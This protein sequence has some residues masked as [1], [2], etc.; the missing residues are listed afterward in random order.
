MKVGMEGIA[1][2]N[3]QLQSRSSL[4][5]ATKKIK[6][7]GRMYFLPASHFD[8]GDDETFNNRSQDFNREE[9]SNSTRSPDALTFEDLSEDGEVLNS[10]S[11]EFNYMA[12][13]RYEEVSQLVNYE[14]KTGS[15]GH[16]RV[17]VSSSPPK[18]TYKLT[19]D[20]NSLTGEVDGIKFTCATPSG[21]SQTV[22]TSLRSLNAT[23][24]EDLSEGE[25]EIV[26]AYS[27]DDKD[28][29]TRLTEDTFAIYMVIDNSHKM[30][31]NMDGSEA[32]SPDSMRA[33]YMREGVTRLLNRLSD[34]ENIYVGIQGFFSFA[35]IKQKQPLSLLSDY[36]NLAMFRSLFDPSSF[37]T[38][39][40]NLLAMPDNMDPEEILAPSIGCNIGDG[41]R[42]GL[43]NVI[44]ETASMPELSNSKKYL[45]LTTAGSPDTQ[46][47]DLNI[48]GGA[49]ATRSFLQ[50]NVN[51]SAATSYFYYGSTP[52][53]AG[54]DISYGNVTAT[55][56]PGIGFYGSSGVINRNIGVFYAR[57]MAALVSAE[58]AFNGCFIVGVG[59]SSETLGAVTVAAVA[60]GFLKISSGVGVVESFNTATM[61]D[62][63]LAFEDIATIIETAVNDS[64]SAALQN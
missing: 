36:S 58:R 5:L 39:F 32:S 29:L 64:L 9:V 15:E 10:R 52:L 55:E 17:I 16:D 44:N 35:S 13:E 28:S 7:S 49:S 47:Y 2:F 4:A 18:F 63:V 40:T 22:T 23:A 12:V 45:I 11:H 30:L 59:T 51:E 14:P 34:Y 50:S 6:N 42:M 53:A 41:I 1:I 56:T 38:N 19:L 20:R 54:D 3:A 24:V 33:Y 25:E 27:S 46:T 31:K 21:K 62:L 48:L 57:E 37:V 43:H 60:E 61:S 26:I 8:R